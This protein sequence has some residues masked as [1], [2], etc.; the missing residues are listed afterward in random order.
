MKTKLFRHSI[1]LS[2]KFIFLKSFKLKFALIRHLQREQPQCAIKFLLVF[3]FAI[4]NVSKLE[5]LRQKSAVSGKSLD[6]P[7]KVATAKFISHNYESKNFY[8]PNECIYNDSIGA[9]KFIF[10]CKVSFVVNCFSQRSITVESGSQLLN[11]NNGSV[12]SKKL[13]SAFFLLLF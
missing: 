7:L 1:G 5:L 12:S 13:C 4:T 10:H 11:K 9:E 2:I 6:I 8:H 3:Q